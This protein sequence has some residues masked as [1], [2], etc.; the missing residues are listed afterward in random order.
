MSQFGKLR[1]I[2]D[3]LLIER[4]RQM[5]KLVDTL[6]VFPLDKLTLLRRLLG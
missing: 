5:V 3:K 2:P 4:R 1:L 6:G